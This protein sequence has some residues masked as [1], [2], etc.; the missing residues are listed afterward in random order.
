MA[1]RTGAREMSL[2]TRKEIYIATAGSAGASMFF[3]ADGLGVT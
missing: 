2:A 3:P 1:G